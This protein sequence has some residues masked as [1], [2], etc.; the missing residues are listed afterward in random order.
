MSEHER[1]R[2]H[3]EPRKDLG[4]GKLGWAY[5]AAMALPVLGFFVFGLV[6]VIVG[7]VLGGIVFAVLRAAD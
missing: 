3:D 4:A 2:T 6:G 7:L 5:I 1:P